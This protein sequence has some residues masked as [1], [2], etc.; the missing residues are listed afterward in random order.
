MFVDN[1]KRIFADFF[2]KLRF[3]VHN[4]VSAPPNF[5]TLPGLRKGSVVYQHEG[6]LY[7][8]VKQSD[9]CLSLKCQLHY[10]IECPATASL[11]I[12]TNKIKSLKVTTV[13]EEFPRFSVDCPECNAEIEGFICTIVR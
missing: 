10:K 7:Y 12:A 3:F 2:S 8:K 11:N 9:T 5:T 6:F 1:N 4:P 13:N